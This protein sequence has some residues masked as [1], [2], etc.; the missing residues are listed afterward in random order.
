LLGSNFSDANKRNDPVV[1]WQNPAIFASMI[2]PSYLKKRDK[3]G[4]VATAKKV[5][6]TN[7]E[8]GIKILQDWGLQ[9]EMGAHVFDVHNQF[10]GTDVHR[11][12]DFQRMIND[13]EI[14]AI[15]MV[16]GG[17]GTTRIIDKV[18]FE[19]L[20]E[21]PKW[22]CGFSDITAILTHLFRLGISSIH[23]PMPSFFYSLEQKQLGWLQKM[24]FGD[25]QVLTVKGEQLNRAGEVQAKMVGGNLSIICHTI[26]TRSEIL[27]KDNI[28]F[29]EDVGEQL[30]HLDRM[31]V[32]LKRAG[33]LE[34]LAGLVVG[35]FTDM[36]DDDPFG[37]TANE[38]IND[39]IQGYD[40]PVAFNFPVGHTKDNYALP[41]GVECRFT[42]DKE[43]AT[44]QL[45]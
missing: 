33:F 13:P 45:G 37:M 5:D 17:Y 26:G 25:R 2:I 38:I 6:R 39:H 15:F 22:I 23:S 29:I 44:I 12:R 36:K 4:I 7:T 11:A 31:M 28:L 18:N 27:T 24:I 42:V 8:L 19:K 41:V 21:N 40:F 10:A 3:V 9:V 16:R 30:Y 14:R 35:Q 43:K 34:D 1:I 20:A 32:Q